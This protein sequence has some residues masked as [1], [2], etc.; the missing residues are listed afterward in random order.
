VKRLSVDQDLAAGGGIGPR[1]IFIS[2]LLPAPFSPS[3]RGSHRKDRQIHTLERVKLA[4][5]FGNAAHL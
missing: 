2:V 5:R 3:A 1:E 4:K